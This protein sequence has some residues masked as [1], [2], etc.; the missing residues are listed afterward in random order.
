VGVET[1]YKLLEDIGKNGMKFF[2]GNMIEEMK[3]SFMYYLLE[4]VIINN[5]EAII[6]ECCD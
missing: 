6:I 1:I 5:E 2:K 4:E 3:A